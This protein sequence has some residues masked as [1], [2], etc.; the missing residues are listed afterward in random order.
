[1][2][3]PEH[4]GCQERLLRFALQV[5]CE[6]GPIDAQP[7]RTARV[8]VAAGVEVA[9]A[10]DVGEFEAGDAGEHVDIVEDVVVPGFT[11]WVDEEHDVGETVVVVQDVGEVDDGFVAFVRGRAGCRV[12]GVERGAY[13]RVAF[14]EGGEPGYIF[15][16]EVA[17]HDC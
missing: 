4:P 2:H 7:V 15:G 3:V 6:P 16:G 8:E 13:V 9:L 17:G 5:P 1:M 10:H 14:G 11:V 12:Y